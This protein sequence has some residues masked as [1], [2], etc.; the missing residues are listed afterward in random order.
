MKKV[1]IITHSGDNECIDI[2]SR[3][4]QEYGAEA[5]RFNADEYPLHCSLS[6]CYE[7]GT[8]KLYFDRK[9]VRSDIS[10][11]EALWYRRSFNLGKGLEN[12]LEKEFLASTYGEI[13]ATLFGMLESLDCFQ[14]G[15]YSAYRRLDSKEEQLKIASQLGLLVPESCITNNPEEAKRFVLA[16]PN[17][18]ITKMQSAF[19]IYRDGQEHVVFT[20]TITRDNLDEISDLQ[21]C[22]MQ[23]QEKIEKQ[24]ELRVTIVGDKVFS[25]A[26]DS[27]KLENAQTDWRKEGNTL[28]A[29]WVPYPLPQDIEDKLLRMM[30]LYGINYG[31]ADLIITPDN[32]CF[33]LE[34]NAAGEFFWL[35][36][37]NG[38][39]ISDQLAKVL[40]GNAP[41]R[42]RPVFEQDT[43]IGA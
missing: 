32:R 34:I 37:L 27:Q 4:L 5:I 21:Y 18:V 6:T 30:D 20:N 15:K 14:I 40:S 11:L 33:F 39:A 29:D 25:F 42:Y 12:I 3:K 35:D 23:F 43:L 16:H 9:G 26:I 8:W 24:V 13:R 19:A 31:A 7:D 38:G 10:N 22:P 2:V 1:L 36:R 17:G 28:L 41:R